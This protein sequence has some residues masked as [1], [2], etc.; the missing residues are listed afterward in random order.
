MQIP[1]VSN[2]PNDLEELAGSIIDDPPDAATFIAYIALKQPIP[3]STDPAPTSGSIVRMNPMIE[4][5]QR[6]GGTSGP[7]VGLSVARL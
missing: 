1:Q 3:T 5:V 7:P 6:I 4:P 2:P